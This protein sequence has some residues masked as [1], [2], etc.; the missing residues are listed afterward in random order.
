V[1]WCVHGEPPAAAALRDA[2]RARLRWECD[3]AA[4]GVLTP[5]CPP[6]HVVGDLT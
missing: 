1:T 3:V 6:Q 5:I 4:D 2:I